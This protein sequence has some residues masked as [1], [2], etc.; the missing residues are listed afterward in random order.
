MSVAVGPVVDVSQA[1][2]DFYGAVGVIIEEYYTSQ[3][4]CPEL[5]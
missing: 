1:L 3:V 4:Q 5:E 2:V